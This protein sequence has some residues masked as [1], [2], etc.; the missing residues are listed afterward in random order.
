M[1]IGPKEWLAIEAELEGVAMDEG[2]AMPLQVG[3][4]GTIERMNCAGTWDARRV[5]E[6]TRM[7]VSCILGGLCGLVVLLYCDFD[8]EVVAQGW[9]CGRW[10]C[11]WQRDDRRRNRCR[12]LFYSYFLCI[13]I[14]QGGF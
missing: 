4:L 11:R 12:G 13:V 3:T 5:V 8:V 10:Y 7:E 6:T 2:T 1:C 9:R 14:L